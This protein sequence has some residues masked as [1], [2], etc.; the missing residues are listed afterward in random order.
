M[1]HHLSIAVNGQPR[2]EVVLATSEPLENITGLTVIFKRSAESGGGS[3]FL[4]AMADTD[5][6]FDGAYRFRRW[7]WWPNFAAGIY[8]AQKVEVQYTDGNSFEIPL[9]DEIV[10]AAAEP[11]A[12]E[13]PVFIAR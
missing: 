3:R 13:M 12:T 5:D 8:R 2:D 4:R 7:H 10:V 1:R 11:A 6:F 9:N